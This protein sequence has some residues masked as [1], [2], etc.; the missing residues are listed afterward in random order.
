[1]NKL[2]SFNLLILLLELRG[3]FER[4][5][6]IPAKSGVSTG[7]SGRDAAE[8]ISFVALS[9]TFTSADI[10]TQHSKVETLNIIPVIFQPF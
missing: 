7:M 3:Y 9:E 10:C 8:T 6:S 5:A 4:A 2:N 1:L